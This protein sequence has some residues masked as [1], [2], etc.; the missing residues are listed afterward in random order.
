MSTEIN[1]I[2]Q[3][4]T[5]AR[6]CS[7]RYIHAN[8]WIAVKVVDATVAIVTSSEVSTI[9]AS[10]SFRVAA[11]CMSVAFASLT[12]WEVPKAGFAL[13]TGSAISI[14]TAFAAA[15]L[16]IA[17]VI[18]STNAIAIARNASFGTKSICSRRATIATPAHHIR[19]TWTHSAVVFTQKTA[20]SRRITLTS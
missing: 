17:E 6:T 18:E 13:T 5:R 3:K 16:N 1:K 8:S 12:V 7:T 19:F 20:W 14:G 10:S 2:F 15:S 11:I 4:F 9:N